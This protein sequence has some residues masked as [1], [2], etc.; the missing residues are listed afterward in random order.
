MPKKNNNKKGN[1]KE[2]K[3]LVPTEEIALAIPGMEEGVIPGLECVDDSDI[4]LP[5]LALVQQMSK[6]VDDHDEDAPKPGVLINTLTMEQYPPPVEVVPVFYNKAAIKFPSDPSEPI[7][8]QSRDSVTGMTH[9]ICGSCEFYWGDWQHGPPACSVIHEFICVFKK[10]EPLFALPF[11]VSMMRSSAKTGKQWLSIASV[12]RVPL[13]AAS[14]EIG[15][16]YRK[17]DKGNFY[18]YSVR[19]SGRIDPNPYGRLYQSMFKAYK[20]GRIKTDYEKGE[21]RIT[22]GDASFNP[23]EFE[24]Q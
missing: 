21:D 8:C 3:A 15:A 19:P 18:V 5:R 20:G 13:F 17:N 6:C 10:D 24:D 7:E 2:E 23:D 14:Y 12:A 4:I 1:A 16:D 22:D 11:I 9:G